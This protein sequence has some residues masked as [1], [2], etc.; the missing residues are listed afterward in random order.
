MTTRDI[1]LSRI[2]QQSAG[3]A[4]HTRG[5]FPE[6]VWQLPNLQGSLDSGHKEDF[7]WR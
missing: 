2:L 7:E 3:R 1:K 5:D 4:Y 6:I